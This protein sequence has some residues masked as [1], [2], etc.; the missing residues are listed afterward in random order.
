MLVKDFVKL[1]NQVNDKNVNMTFK[2]GYTTL[3]VIYLQHALN[4]RAQG[5]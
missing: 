5:K 1:A 2:A 4:K 3:A